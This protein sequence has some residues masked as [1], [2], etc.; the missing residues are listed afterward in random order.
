MISPPE[1]IAKA[2]EQK[3]H[4]SRY[5]PSERAKTNLLIDCSREILIRKEDTIEIRSDL[6][7]NTMGFKEV[8]C[9]SGNWAVPQALILAP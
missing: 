3:A 5:G 9:A 1:W 2:P 7:G 6:G 4:P 8:W